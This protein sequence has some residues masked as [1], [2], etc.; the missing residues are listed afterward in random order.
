[1]LSHSMPGSL[2]ACT[3]TS[4][5]ALASSLVSHLPASPPKTGQLNKQAQAS[6]EFPSHCSPTSA[7]TWR[8]SK[9]AVAT[10]GTKLRKKPTIVVDSELGQA[11]DDRRALGVRLARGSLAA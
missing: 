8:P 2:R 7:H 11:G 3:A 10:N 6:G 1:M 4:T 5:M 9:A